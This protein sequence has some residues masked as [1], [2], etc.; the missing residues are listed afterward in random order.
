MIVP[1]LPLS[2]FASAVSDQQTSCTS[3]SHD[4][5]VSF[6]VLLFYF[7]TSHACIYKRLV[8]SY[9]QKIMITVRK[10]RNVTLGYGYKLGATALSNSMSEDG[11]MINR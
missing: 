2:S 4:N 7:V 10:T 3:I 11:K 6:I 9:S 1:S 8:N 5:S